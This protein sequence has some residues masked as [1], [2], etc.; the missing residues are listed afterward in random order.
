VEDV[1]WQA[2]ILMSVAFSQRFLCGQLRKI[3]ICGSLSVYLIRCAFIGF[4]IGITLYIKVVVQRGYW[5]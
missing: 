5:A 2:A 3:S 1:S 4:C